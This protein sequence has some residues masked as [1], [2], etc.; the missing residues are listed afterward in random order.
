ME[1]KFQQLIQ[2]TAKFS[3]VSHYGNEYIEKSVFGKSQRS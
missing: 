2:L 3:V 1:S